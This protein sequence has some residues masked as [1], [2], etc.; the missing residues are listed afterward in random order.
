MAQAYDA[1]VLIDAAQAVDVQ[2]LGVD[3]LEFS[4]HKMCVPR[5]VGILYEKEEL[6]EQGYC[7]GDDD[8]LVEPIVLGGGALSN[9]THD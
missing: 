8:G 3:F 4:I 2:E 9:S 7:E 6:F 1:R 5:G